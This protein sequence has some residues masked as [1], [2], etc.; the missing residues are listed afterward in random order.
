MV[1]DSGDAGAAAATHSGGK[2]I[3]K[4]TTILYPDD[5]FVFHLQDGIQ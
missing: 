4:F 5:R 2:T 3:D 1:G